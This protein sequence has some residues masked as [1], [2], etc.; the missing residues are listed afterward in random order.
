MAKD[1]ITLR[2]AVCIIIVFIFGSTLVIGVSTTSEQD[3][4]I[5]FLIAV[6]ESIP[7]LL[8]YARV[9]KL[10]PEK[11]IFEIFEALFG[12]VLGK[13][14]TAF[15]CWYAIHLGALVVKN[16]SE[17]IVLTGMD[18]TPQLPVMI[19]M[20]LVAVY[21]VKSGAETLGKW[22]LTVFP[23]I[24]LVILF[25][26]LISLDRLDLSN[27][28]PVFGHSLSSI[29][30]GSFPTVTFPLGETVLFLA[31]ANAVKK[32][33][34]PKRIYISALVIS[35]LVLLVVMIRNLG[36]VGSKLLSSEYFP[37]YTAARVIHPADYLMRIEGFI[38]MNF[39]FTGV[40]KVT[41]CLFAASKGLASLFG[42]K[43]YKQMVM[44]AGLLTLALCAIL[45]KSV[46]E[47]FGFVK[48]Y[49]YYALPFEFLIP[50]IVWITA[51][52]KNRKKKQAVSTQ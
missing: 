32:T 50:I 20:V 27:L 31:L 25:T 29:V 19:M 42:I 22:S 7:I 4:W 5:S 15:I 16:F 23:A 3:S 21:M 45:Y 17:F 12:K 11:N 38:T 10:F 2:Q 49:M 30:S 24:C 33:D 51:E 14:F 36:T 46:M 35:S 39:I 47:M 43:D 52:I 48:T 34:S 18:Q 40:T 28:Q 13:V 26:V 1:T 37:S 8:I 6:V 41:V 44:P 9:M